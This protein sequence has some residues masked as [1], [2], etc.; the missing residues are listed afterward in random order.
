M[1]ITLKLLDDWK[2]A[3]N[4]E[5][6]NQAALRL[7]LGRQ[8][9]S[10]WRNEDREAEDAT[11]VRLA[12]DLH[13]DADPYL[14]AIAQKRASTPELKSALARLAK[15]IGHISLATLIS[16]SALPHSTSENE[17]TEKYTSS[18]SILSMYIMSNFRIDRRRR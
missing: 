18:Q 4:I 13:R 9:I 8:A 2:A 11:V 7:G 16:V 17:S 14:I 12:K 6:D 1:N 3:N 5:S 10:R 15:A